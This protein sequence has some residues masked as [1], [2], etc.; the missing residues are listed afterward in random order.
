MTGLSLGL[1]LGAVVCLA[2]DASSDQLVR[3]GIYCVSLESFGTPVHALKTGERHPQTSFVMSNRA[4]N[5]DERRV[6]SVAPLNDEVFRALAALKKDARVCLTANR[7]TVRHGLD[8]LLAWR[9]DA[10][11][12][13][14]CTN[15]PRFDE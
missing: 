7:M 9:I 6:Y 12:D 14:E 2:T 13:F 10:C 5:E 3:V 8:L 11:D 15:V 1:A 4:E